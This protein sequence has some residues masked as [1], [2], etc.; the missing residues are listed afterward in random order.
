MTG[1]SY[2]IGEL[3]LP[4]KLNRKEKNGGTELMFLLAKNTVYSYILMYSYNTYVCFHSQIMI[5]HL[6]CLIKP[7]I[8]FTLQ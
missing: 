7:S 4:R 6:L 1:K 2:A 8:P 3:K 5:Q